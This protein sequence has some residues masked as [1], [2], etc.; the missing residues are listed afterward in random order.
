[1]VLTPRGPAT[2]FPAIGFGTYKLNGAEGVEVIKRA[3]GHGYRLF[4]SAFNYENEGA[5]GKA[6][7]EAPLDREQLKL[8]SKLPGR[9]HSYK[10]ALAAIEES[11]FR[12][13]LDY[14]DIYLIHWPNPRVGKYVEAW[15]ALIEARE[16]ELVRTI[17]VSNFLPKHLERIETATGVRPTVNQIELHPYFPQLK[18]LAYHRE[19]G[20][21]TEA[22]SPLGRGS[23]LLSNSVI[24]KIAKAHNATPGQVVLAWHRALGSVPLPK[25]QSDARQIENIASLKLVLTDAEFAAITRLG[26]PDGR[27]HDQDPATYEEF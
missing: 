7:R 2:A 6:I 12:S 14:I 15:Q 27:L 22:W 25:A 8:T 11:V 1:L 18:A 24:K 5:V 10:E 26:R 21:V 4:D 3:I 13:G 19:W 16:R 9:H 17:G 20:I 23:D